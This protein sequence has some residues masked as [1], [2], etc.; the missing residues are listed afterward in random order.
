VLGT[1]G[2]RGWL[3]RTGGEW[4][5]QARITVGGTSARLLGIT[6]KALTECGWNG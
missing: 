3:V 5:W 4:R 2:E 1:W 6:P